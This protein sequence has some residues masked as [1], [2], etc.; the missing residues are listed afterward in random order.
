MI[1]RL[2]L[3]YDLYPHLY[4]FINTQKVVIL[5]VINLMMLGSKCQSL[6]LVL[7]TLYCALFSYSKLTISPTVLIY[8]HIVFKNT[9]YLH[10]ILICLLLC[11]S[12]P[13]ISL[14][15]CSWLLIIKS[16]C[17]NFFLIFLFSSLE[18]HIFLNY[19][20]PRIQQKLINFLVSWI[21]N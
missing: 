9:T 11:Y 8:S 15:K 20:L 5:Q 4:Y 12:L 18:Q 10:Q 1:T 21:K 6:T 7:I 2:Y 14:M 3:Y 13:I 16:S 17:L 19:V